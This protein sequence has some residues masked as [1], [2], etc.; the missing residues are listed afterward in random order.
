MVFSC[1]SCCQRFRFLEIPPWLWRGRVYVAWKNNFFSFV[2]VFFCFLDILSKCRMVGYIEVE[3]FYFSL[4]LFF[5]CFLEIPTASVLVG[6]MEVGRTFFSCCSCFAFCFGD[7]RRVWHSSV[8]AGGKNIFFPFVVGILRVLFCFAD[9][10]S[11]LMVGSRSHNLLRLPFLSTEPSP[12][13]FL[14]EKIKCRS[15]GRRKMFPSWV[16]ESTIRDRKTL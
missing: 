9:P 10:H 12:I 8:Y 2:V 6:F 1:C 5:F 16:A 14:A 15:G 3:N 4:L 13:F 7:P 11:I